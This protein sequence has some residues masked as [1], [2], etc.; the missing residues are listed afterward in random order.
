MI[1]TPSRL[2]A[3]AL[4]AAAAAV[5]AGCAGVP[6]QPGQSEADALRA[7]GVP[8]G[9]Y[10]L[11]DG[12]VRLEFASGPYGRETWMVDVDRNGRVVQA[13]QVLDERVFA[14]LTPGMTRDEVLRLIGRPAE[15]ERLSWLGREAWSYRYPT[16]D[17]QWF[18]ITFDADGRLRQAGGYHVDPLCDFP[19]L[20]EWP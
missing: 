2:H 3:A 14:T 11:A 18:S 16:Y 12:A 1:R 6:V 13:R 19:S 10:A 20:G 17:C 4:A 15:R 7:L 9:R 8:T 5:L